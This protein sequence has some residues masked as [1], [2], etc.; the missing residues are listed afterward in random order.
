MTVGQIVT[1]MRARIADADPARYEYSDAELIGYINDAVRY[2]ADHVVRMGDPSPLVT[3][4]SLRSGDDLPADVIAWAGQYPLNVSGGKVYPEY[5]I[6]ARFFAYPAPATALTDTLPLSGDFSKIL[7][8][9]TVLA[10][11]RN[12]FDQSQ[13]LA[14]PAMIQGLF[15]G[16]EKK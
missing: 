15:G 16:A 4:T 8:V 14:I 5:P 12:D 10:R 7:Q 13:D 9:A 3:E 6:R 1:L 11:R 2:V